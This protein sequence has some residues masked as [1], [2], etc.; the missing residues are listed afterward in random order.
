[1]TQRLRQ[2]TPSDLG[3][4]AVQPHDTENKLDQWKMYAMFACSFPPNDSE[5]GGF[6][7]DFSFTKS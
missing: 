4:K 7:I 1:M 2:I 3:G 6:A 5:D